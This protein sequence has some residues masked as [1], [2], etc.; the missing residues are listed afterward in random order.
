[1]LLDQAVFGVDNRDFALNIFPEQQRRLQHLLQAHDS[2]SQT[3]GGDLEKESAVAGP[4]GGIHISCL[5]L[6]PA[7]QPFIIAVALTAVKQQVFQQVR[8]TGEARRFV[9]AAGGNPH[10]GRRA[11]GL[12]L[13]NQGSLQAARQSDSAGRQRHYS[14]RVL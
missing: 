12:R 6:H 13:M 11:I 8:Q 3:L 5:A 7:H 10:Q 2:V 9:V 4:G 1:M 14:S